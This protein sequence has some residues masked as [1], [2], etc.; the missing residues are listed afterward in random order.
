VLTFRQSV[1]HRSISTAT[2]RGRLYTIREDFGAWK[3][4]ACCLRAEE[5]TAWIGS[6]PTYDKAVAACNAHARKS[7]RR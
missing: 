7:A 5:E 4:V 6:F 2:Q 1:V 3:A